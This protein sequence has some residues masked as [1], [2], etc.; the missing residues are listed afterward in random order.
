VTRKASF[1]PAQ[2][3]PRSIYSTVNKL[4]FS[5]SSGIVSL[6]MREE[7]P[8]VTLSQETCFHCQAREGAAIAEEY[9]RKSLREIK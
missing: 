3:F 6:F 9:G 8:V 7:I 4:F 2:Y 5:P 1:S